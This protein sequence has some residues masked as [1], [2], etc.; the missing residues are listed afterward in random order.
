MDRLFPL[1]PCLGELSQLLLH[2][3]I[4]VGVEDLPLLAAASQDFD[5]MKRWDRCEDSPRFDQGMH[6]AMEKGEQEAAD[7]GT[8][9]IGI[10][11][12][13]DPA[14]PSIIELEG[15]TR[16]CSDHLDD[17]GALGVIEHL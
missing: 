2:L 10:R 4:G 6:V 17:R 15:L 8:I 5:P 12:Q 14:I 16:S 3:I 13:D 1:L 11:H 9:D 7:V